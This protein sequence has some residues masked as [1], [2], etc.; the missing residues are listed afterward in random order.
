MFEVD[1]SE[2]DE[3]F[4]AAGA[5][6]YP[7]AALMGVVNR[8]AEEA[9]HSVAVV[10]YTRPAGVTPIPTAETRCGGSRRSTG[11]PIQP[12]SSSSRTANTRLRN[13]APVG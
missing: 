4:E 3:A 6:P 7:W 1:R 5:D 2:C 11:T 10:A 9:G 12:A 8:L 13:R